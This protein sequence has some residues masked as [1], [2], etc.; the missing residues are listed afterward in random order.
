[1]QQGAGFGQHGLGGHALGSQHGS[2]SQQQDANMNATALSA[3]KEFNS[4]IN[5][6][7]L[8]VLLFKHHHFTLF[9][10]SLI[11]FHGLRLKKKVLP[12]LDKDFVKNTPQIFKTL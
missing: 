12:L 2:L 3:S 10:L 4:F 5:T 7:I 1:M 8:C 6:P 9:Q 11:D